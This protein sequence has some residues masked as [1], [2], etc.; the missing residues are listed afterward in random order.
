M[1][2][3][4]SNGG[5]H[6][7]ITIKRL[8]YAWNLRGC[9]LL[10]LSLQG[11]L[12]FLAPFRKRARRIL[13]HG[14]VW[15]AYL[16]C[17]WIAAVAIGLISKR[18]GDARDQRPWEGSNEEEDFM[19]FWASFLLLHLGGPDTITSFAIED[20]QFWL[21][22]F[23]G[24]V[25]HLVSTA[26]IFY[27]TFPENNKLWIP[28]AMVFVAG[29]IK[30]AE[31]TRALYLASS[32]QFGRSVLLPKP[33]PGPDYQEAVT[34]Y[35]YSDSIDV[36]LH[37]EV[38]PPTPETARPFK[39]L[40]PQVPTQAEVLPSLEATFKDLIQVSTHAEVMP[41]LE[42]PAG[43]SKD[44]EYDVKL[45]Q[46]AHGLFERFKGLIVGYRLSSMDREMS[47]QYFLTKNATEAF[48]LIA[49]ELNFMYD[50]LHTKVVVVRC[51]LGYIF[52]VISFLSILGAL[53]IF[54]S[55]EKQS[56]FDNKL[57]IKLSYALLVGA[58][59]FETTTVLALIFSDWTVIALKINRWSKL[60]A[61]IILK[62]KRWSGS[63]SRYDMISNC[64]KGPPAWISR[65]AAHV[66]LGGLP[67][68][69]NIFLSSHSEMVSE[70]LEKFIFD[71]LRM[72]SLSA[73]NLKAAMDA[74]S[75]RGDWALMQ[76]SSCF[77]L[78]WSV[79]EYQYA[80][81]LLLWHVATELLYQTES[82]CPDQKEKAPESHPADKKPNYKEICKNLSDYMFYIPV[83]QPAVM[84]PVLGNW[85][86]A[87]QDTREEAK[88]F[89]R[90][91][92]KKG[93]KISQQ[94]EACKQVLEVDT[95]KFR[96][97]VVKGS[98]S[99]SV[100]FDACIL[101]K[102][103]SEL[104]IDGWMVMSRVWVELMC[105]AAIKC[106]P[107]VHAK[108]PSKG[109]EL[110]TFVWLLMNHLGLGTQFYEQE[111]QTRTEMV[112]QTQK[113]KQKNQGPAARPD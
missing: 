47:Q 34:I 9:I 86:T 22:H 104:D 27:Q 41:T 76:T 52:R 88:R 63:I 78:N 112:G 31:R 68:K 89:F 21:R 40:I 102:Q 8:W 113:N 18:K 92:R 110:L 60:I 97:V 37:A 26:Y 5:L 64:L 107:F 65:L 15:V 72:K 73:T 90:K 43:E 29:T 67:E 91:I 106:T 93:I 14:G 39:D 35:S 69:I 84:A 109:G 100:L 19:A 44:F 82:S 24:L 4:V 111:R 1:S 54:R 61:K 105:F 53:L 23:T 46:E 71:Q 70:D 75:R 50:L 95:S 59:G 38:M 56:E 16:L 85:E 7:F 25:V 32:G 98:K 99:K 77:Q 108:Q 28:T 48:R 10:S 49:C 51:K 57:D 45:V 17:D 66:R 6:R 96:P 3:S 30:Y 94:N 2:G 83:M 79:E 87:F 36:P 81:S 103:L 13:L 62:R 74:C 101:A 12:L 42:S 80:Q 58:L 20:N 55:I 33:D 11:S